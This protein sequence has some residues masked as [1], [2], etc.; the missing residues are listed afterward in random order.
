[1]SLKRGGNVFIIHEVG[2][3]FLAATVKRHSH[4]DLA[5]RDTG[6]QM[7]L[8]GVVRSELAGPRTLVQGRIVMRR[9]S[10]VVGHHVYQIQIADA[11]FEV[12]I[13]GIA[14]RR[15]RQQFLLA[16]SPPQVSHQQGEVG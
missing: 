6:S 7:G 12:D 10:H 4:H 16:E 2:I 3:A 14:Y 8:H 5:G 1:M 15:R 9:P 11:A 13:L